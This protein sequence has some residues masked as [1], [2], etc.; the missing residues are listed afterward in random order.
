MPGES[1]VDGDAVLCLADFCQSLVDETI[2]LGIVFG[3]TVCL[4]Y[5]DSS[6][7]PNGPKQIARTKMLV[8]ELLR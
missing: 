5:V 7:A 3:G 2:N 4:S 1:R 6:F 8:T